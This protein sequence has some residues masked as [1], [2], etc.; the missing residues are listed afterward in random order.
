M[1]SQITV[2]KKNVTNCRLSYPSFN[3]KRC[4]ILSFL[5]LALWRSNCQKQSIYYTLDLG[6]FN[7]EKVKCVQTWKFATD[8]FK[9]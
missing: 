1:N 4:V 2:V 7:K 9:P 8:D 5:A 3:G 6:D